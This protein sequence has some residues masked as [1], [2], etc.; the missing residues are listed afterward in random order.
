ME[1]V[2]SQV[3]KAIH[4]KRAEE[5]LQ[6][7]EKKYKQL[8]DNSLTGIYITQDRILKFCNQ[9]FAEIFGYDSPEEILGIQIIQLVFPESW[10]IVDEEIRWREMGE[11]ETSRYEFK[12]VKKDK[13]VIDVEVLG[14]RVLYDGIP[15]MQGTMID[16]TDRKRAENTIRASE[17]RY[18]QLFDFLPYGGEVLDPKGNIIE[19]SP[20]T[21]RMLGYG[22]DELTGKHITT[23]LD[24]D[25]IAIFKNKFPQII[26]GK[27]VSAEIG[28]IRK[29]GR[30]LNILRAA[31]LLYGEDGKTVTG[32]LALNVDIT[33]RK[34][35]EQLL[36]LTHD[37][38]I[39]LSAVMGIDETLRLCVD[40]AIKASGL[41]SGGV[42]LVD[43]N[44]D[45]AL[46]LFHNAVDH[47][48][49]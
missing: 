38:G 20:S 34:M 29:D 12:C 7:S 19:C 26:G 39:A 15:A 48:E 32:V 11:K 8:I 2:S 42:Y 35:A 22:R 47:R 40:A 36:Q 13:T 43:E 18:R 3:A 46:V 14:G 49:T 45:T 25:S 31:Q 1:Y 37:L 6:Q 27:A 21:A 10:N 33:E 24:K 44:I 9:N 16:I 4:R 17:K 5:A 30:V 28:M 23:L 41:D